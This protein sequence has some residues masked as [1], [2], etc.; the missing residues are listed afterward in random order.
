MNQKIPPMQSPEGGFVIQDIEL[1]GYSDKLEERT[2]ISAESELWAAFQCGSESALA[3][4]FLNYSDKLFNYGRQFTQD[5]EL[6]HDAI[7]DVFYGLIKNKHRLGIARSVKFYLYSSFRRRLIRLL[8]RNQR[9]VLG[10]Q[11]IDEGSFKIS[12]NPYHHDIQNE[13]SP[14]QRKLLDDAF[15]KIPA[16]Q[17]EVLL[18]YFFEDASYKEIAETMGFSQ[19]KSARKLLYRALDRLHDQLEKHRHL[20]RLLLMVA[21]GR[22]FLIG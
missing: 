19:V 14:D 1:E 18:L 3:E 16:R 7:Q 11:A 10:E 2:D 22:Y 12:V 21:A 6:I 13:V 9:M 15:T 17:R 20:L 5:Q 4:I 8:R